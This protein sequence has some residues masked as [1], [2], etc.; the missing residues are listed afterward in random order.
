M[1]HEKMDNNHWVEERLA[2]LDPGNFRPDSTAAWARLSSREGAS[3]RPRG[4][5]WWMWAMLSGAAAVAAGVVLLVVSTPSACANPLGCKQASTP[6]PSPAELPA[7]LPSIAPAA[8]PNPAPVVTPPP[9]AAATPAR[10][11]TLAHMH[12]FKE[13]GSPTAPIVCEVYTDY[14]CPHCALFYQD[15]V[16][17]LMKEYVRTGKVRLLHRDFPLPQHPY[18][19]LAARY[20]NAAGQL[21]Y[22]DVVVSQLFKT[23]GVWS[24]D[25]DVDLQVA[26]VLPQAILAKVRDLVKARSGTDESVADDQ[27]M[28]AQDDVHSTPTV[29][30]VAHGKRQ[31]LPGG[32]SFP[33]LK[34]YLDDTLA[35]K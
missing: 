8:V 4:H 6:A 3:Q 31:A 35:K 5:R 10:S 2:S 29:V 13:S 22:Y 12:S 15:T 30:I 9:V 7:P 24:G 33:L 23:Q 11:A 32:V 19:W 17:Q 21:G 20:A 28:A 18:A 34:S 27:E 26:P 14:Q 1:E 16:P 25:G